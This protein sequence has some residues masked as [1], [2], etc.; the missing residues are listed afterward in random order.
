VRTRH[1]G[2]SGL[3]AQRLL[4]LFIAGWVLFD[5]P[6]LG[7]ALG[8]GPEAT[9]FGLPRLPVVLFAAW[10]ALIVLLAWWMEGP[11]HPQPGPAGPAGSP[12]PERPDEA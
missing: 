6:L 1:P 7:L 8:R 10:A 3:L 11:E 5:F 2:P 4:A 12:R 9:L